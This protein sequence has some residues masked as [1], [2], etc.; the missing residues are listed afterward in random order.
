MAEY[1]LIGT[2]SISLS[3]ESIEQA[4]RYHGYDW[5]LN[6]SGEYGGTFSE[7]DFAN[8]VL[9]EMQANGYFAPS[10]LSGI[11]QED[12]APYMEFYC[13]ATGTQLLSEVEGVQEEQRRI[14]F[15]LHF[16]DTAKPLTVGNI[17]LK[18]PGPAP[19]PDRLR[20]YT[21]YIPVD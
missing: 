19:L 1:T 2:Y 13:D 18:L 4:I 9:I 5:L 21:H 14:C 10:D 11:A 16:A 6:E 12:Q 8:L 17:N 15:F 3:K 7:D 20:P